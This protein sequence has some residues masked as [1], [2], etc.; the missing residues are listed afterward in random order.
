M[1]RSY[2]RWILSVMSSISQSSE[3]WVYIYPTL[4]DEQ[5]VWGKE[6][7][8][9]LCVL[10]GNYDIGN[11]FPFFL[12]SFTC[13]LLFVWWSCKR[14]NDGKERDR[15]TFEVNFIF[16]VYNYFVVWNVLLNQK[17]WACFSVEAFEVSQE[18][19]LANSEF[20]GP[21]SVSVFSRYVQLT[22]LRAGDTMRCYGRRP[23]QT[24]LLLLAAERERCIRSL[25]LC[26]ED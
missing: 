7:G 22:L 25:D 15:D 19:F 17:K 14:M 16:G 21:P 18:S 8:F 20:E 9:W 5:D 26:Q 11:W 13:Y 1:K 4:Q 12:F 2:N 10:L 24:P 3:F 6:D 23:E